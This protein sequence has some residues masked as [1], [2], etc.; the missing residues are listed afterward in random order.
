MKHIKFPLAFLAFTCALSLL[1]GSLGYLK[2]SQLTLELA[3]LVL[4]SG[5]VGGLIG[6]GVGLLRAE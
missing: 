1:M 2:D 5:T 6:V 3:A 4:V